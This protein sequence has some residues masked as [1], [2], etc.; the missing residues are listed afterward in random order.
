MIMKKILII[1]AHGFEEVEAVTPIDILRRGGIDVII[2]GVG[3][4]NI[5][6]SHGIKIQCDTT[7][8]Q[9]D[10]DDYDGV[11]IPGGLPGADNIS[12]SEEAGRFI[13]SIYQGKKLVAAICAS[14]SIVL[15]PLK[16]LDGRKSTGYPGFENR[17]SEFVELK[18]DKVVV[19]GN[20][21]T[22]KGPGTAADFSFAILEYLVGV[23]QAES[24]ARAMLYKL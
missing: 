8:E 24:V 20:I 5:I 12:E 3:E 18:T 16:I 11:V 13:E 21:I 19:D 7:I 15:S 1:L 2:A 23:E 17:F 6:G 9:I 4:S 22:S 10:A 14:P